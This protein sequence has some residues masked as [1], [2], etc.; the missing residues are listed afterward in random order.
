MV[1]IQVN[2]PVLIVAILFKSRGAVG[3]MAQRF[4]FLTHSMIKGGYSVELL[5]TTSLL[6]HLCIPLN[7]KIFALDDTGGSLS[8]NGWLALAKVVLQVALGRYSHVHVSGGGGLTLP[9]L[10][11]AKLRGVGT[12]ATFASRTLSMAAYGNEG[13]IRKWKRILDL[14]DRI[15]V[16]NPGH[17]L[18]KWRPKVRVSPGSF[19][20]RHRE[21]PDEV[22]T[23]REAV[24][25]FCGAFER[26]K[27]PLL[28]IDAFALHLKRGGGGRLVLFG[29]G[30]LSALVD[31]RK[32]M[33]NETAGYEAVTN[34]NPADYFKILSTASAFLSLQDYDNYPSQSLMEAMIMGCRCIATADGD[35]GL[36]FPS[37]G[38]NVIVDSRNPEC[39]SE[40]IYSLMSDNS[41]SLPNRRFALEKH[42][43]QRFTDYFERFAG[44]GRSVL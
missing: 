23:K 36:M 17:D 26:T 24:A 29:N 7:R 6:S 9:L 13:E 11:L 25:V 30:S 44:I 32:K 42:S 1:I 40:A 20:S 10:R 35:T 27:N 3:G 4:A 31:E 41:A 8:A 38:G 43:I 22:A 18:E 33:V 28:A 39:F 12:S 5:T 37:D 15:D 21:M 14:V 34:G 2:K 16:L 19:P